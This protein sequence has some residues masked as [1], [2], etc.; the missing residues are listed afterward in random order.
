MAAK[1]TIAIPSAKNE[2]QTLNWQ[3]N[4]VNKEND[5]KDKQRMKYFF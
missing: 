1:M 5:K 2:R 3:I 4:K